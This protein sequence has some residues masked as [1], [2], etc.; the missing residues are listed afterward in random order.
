[1]RL[2]F[3]LRQLQAITV[4]PRFSC[5]SLGVLG[6]VLGSVLS[7]STIALAEPP[8]P[9]QPAAY[10]V[11]VGFRGGKGDATAAVLDS[12]IKLTD[13][14][15]R[16]LSTRPALMTGGVRHRMAPALHH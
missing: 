5:Q 6:G 11:G 1:M 15:D 7:H 12:K 2:V 16:T 10:Y 4:N 9:T 13:L 14:G 8:P 3:D